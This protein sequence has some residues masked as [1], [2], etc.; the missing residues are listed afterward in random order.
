MA[1]GVSYTDQNARFLA[2]DALTVIAALAAA[3]LVGGAFTR[4]IWPLGLAVGAWLLARSCSAALPQFVQRFKVEPNQFAQESRYI[5]NNIAMTRLAYGLTTGDR[6]NGDAPLTAAV[7]Q[8]EAARSRTPASG[9][10]GRSAR[11][12]TRS[13]RSASTTTSPTSTP[14]A[15]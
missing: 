15:T 2:F 1:A 6:L 9:T 4:L 3:L 11:P 10:T 14:T 13:R 7:V 5:D 12:W 8:E